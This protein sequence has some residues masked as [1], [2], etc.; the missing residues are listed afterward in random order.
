MD[1]SGFGP[2]NK[3]KAGP[4]PDRARAAEIQGLR[5]DRQAL[6]TL[7]AARR[8]RMRLPIPHS[9]P[10]RERL[11]LR[12]LFHVRPILL[13]AGVCTGRLV[14]KTIERSGDRAVAHMPFPI[15]GSGNC[16]QYGPAFV[17]SL[18]KDG[19]SLSGTQSNSPFSRRGARRKRQSRR[20][21]PGGSGPLESQNGNVPVFQQGCPG[22]LSGA[23][24]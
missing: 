4:Q 22:S 11:C 14:R 8:Q 13:R 17:L 3:C 16:R 2:L 10:P 21:P 20:K 9:L 24:Q 18:R 19:H 6:P 12:D 5:P 15:P 23:R 1:R 7:R